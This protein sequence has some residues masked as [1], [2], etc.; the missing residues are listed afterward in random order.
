MVP[1]TESGAHDIDQRRRIA[2]LT[3]SAAVGRSRGSRDIAI[4]MTAHT[5]SA[6]PPS[7]RSGTGWGIAHIAGGFETATGTVDDTEATTTDLLGVCEPGSAQL[8][9]GVVANIAPCRE[10]I[11]F[12]HRLLGLLATTHRWPHTSQNISTTHTAV[13]EQ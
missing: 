6:K 3:H 12:T 2:Q 10:R 9:N 8:R 7:R 1:Q 5:P 4:S 11:T 13:A